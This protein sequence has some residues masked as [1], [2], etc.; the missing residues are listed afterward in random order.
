M[1]QR[2]DFENLLHTFRRFPPQTENYQS[3]DINAC[4]EAKSAPRDAQKSHANVSCLVWWQKRKGS[5]NLMDF[6]GHRPAGAIGNERHLFLN[7]I[8]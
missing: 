2:I 5:P 7:F 8:V 3:S 6:V 4:L 1:N